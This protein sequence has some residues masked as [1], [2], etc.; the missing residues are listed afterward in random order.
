MTM[1]GLGTEKVPDNASVNSSSSSEK[2]D[3]EKPFDILQEIDD[4]LQDLELLDTEDHG[5]HDS[6]RSKKILNT[7]LQGTIRLFTIAEENEERSE[8]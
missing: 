8:R 5:S 6:K 1:G 3:G 4:S 2:M 7:T